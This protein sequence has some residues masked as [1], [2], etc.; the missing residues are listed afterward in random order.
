MNKTALDGIK[1]KKGAPPGSLIVKE[2]YMP[3][4]K[5]AAITVMYKVKDYNPAAGDWFWTKYTPEGKI[6]ASEKAAMCVG[7]HGAKKDNGY[8]YTG[9]VKP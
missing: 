4:K 3:D 7:C 8:L 5:L 9:P 2:N 1:A 6:E